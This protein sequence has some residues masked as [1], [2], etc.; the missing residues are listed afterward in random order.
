MPRAH[1]YYVYIMTNNPSGVLY[2]GVT[3][4]SMSFG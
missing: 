2:V 1:N 3:N 4:N